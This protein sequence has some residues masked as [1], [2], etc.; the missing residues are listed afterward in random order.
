VIDGR[1]LEESGLTAPDEAG[2]MLLQ[3]RLQLL[4]K[5]NVGHRYRKPCSV[6]TSQRQAG[7]SR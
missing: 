2:L 7:R 4:A 5:S 1:N 3:G 6:H